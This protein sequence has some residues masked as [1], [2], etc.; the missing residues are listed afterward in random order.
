MF[1]GFANPT[2]ISSSTMMLEVKIHSKRAWNAGRT[3]R[4][5]SMEQGRQSGGCGQARH[6]EAGLY[7]LYPDQHSQQLRC[8][9]RDYLCGNLLLV[10]ICSYRCPYHPCP[11]SSTCEFRSL[12]L[13]TLTTN[14]LPCFHAT[15]EED[16][17][18]PL[19]KRNTVLQQPCLHLTPRPLR[20]RPCRALGPARGGRWCCRSTR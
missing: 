11:L 13:F 16:V 7:T 3:F 6:L 1:T 10:F 19:V 8:F 17:R 15:E 2:V 14:D 5:K 4:R 18:P 20:R 12:Q 9:S